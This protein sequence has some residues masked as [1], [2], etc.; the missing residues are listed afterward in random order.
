ERGFMTVKCGPEE[1]GRVPLDDMA[2]VLATAR[3]VTYT[4]RLLVELAERNILLVV[5][6][7][8]FRPV[9]WL[10]PLSGNHAQ[11]ARLLAQAQAPA[12]L[13]N[14]LWRDLVVHKVRVQA[15]VVE[16]FGARAGGIATL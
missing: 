9:A 8:N 12:S 15:A 5:C 11:G 16:A 6:S 7:A 4:N 2:V 14:R 10:W 3:G 1:L 13:R